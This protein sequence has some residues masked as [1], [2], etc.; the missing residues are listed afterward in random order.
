MFTNYRLTVEATLKNKMPRIWL[1]N[2]EILRSPKNLVKNIAPSQDCDSRVQ[3]GE[4]EF[5]SI[6]LQVILT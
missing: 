6:V 1:L 2:I 5:C 4:S 3:N